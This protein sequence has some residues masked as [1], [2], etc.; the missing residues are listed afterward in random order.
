MSNDELITRAA[1]YWWEQLNIRAGVEPPE[2]FSN[3]AH[4]SQEA[5]KCDVRIIKQFFDMEQV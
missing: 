3:L 2:P 5:F 4:K 1:A